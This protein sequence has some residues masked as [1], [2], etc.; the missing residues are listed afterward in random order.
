MASHG[1]RGG[2]NFAPEW[3]SLQDIRGLPRCFARTTTGAV[4]AGT[5]FV[6]FGS[7]DPA[8]ALALARSAVAD[9]L[10]R[11]AAVKAARTASPGDAPAIQVVGYRIDS[12]SLNEAD[13]TVAVR[14]SNGLVA[15]GTLRLRWEHSDWR[16]VANPA[17]GAISSL[18]RISS[19]GGFTP[20]EAR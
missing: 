2:P 1:G 15:A 8:Q 10:G 6:A 7:G 17:S 12:F 9:G 20:F 3:S 16:V 19:L 5:N 13:I 18:S 11:T 4:L 14:G